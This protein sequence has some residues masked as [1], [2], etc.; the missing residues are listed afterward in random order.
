MQQRLE[1][2]TGLEPVSPAW[3]AGAQPIYQGRP[4]D[5]LQDSTARVRRTIRWSETRDLLGLG[6]EDARRPINGVRLHSS[7]SFVATSPSM[8]NLR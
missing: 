7:T 3:E 4:C 8:T 1:R 5:R 6:G 2:P